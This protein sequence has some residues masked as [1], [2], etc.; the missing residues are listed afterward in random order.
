MSKHENKNAEANTTRTI[1][2]NTPKGLDVCGVEF[3]L[4]DSDGDNVFRMAIEDEGAGAFI[5]LN[6]DCNEI[7][8]THEELTN[9]AKNG[10]TLCK[11]MDAQHKEESK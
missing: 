3:T 11:Q 2:F 10:E 7:R 8:L 1:E 9:I 4:I 6:A 5:I